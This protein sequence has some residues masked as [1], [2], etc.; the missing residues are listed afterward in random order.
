VAIAAALHLFLLFA[1]KPEFF[2]VFRHS[3]DDSPSAA[4]PSTSYP[5]AIA[6]IPIEI[7]ADHPVP[8]RIPEPRSNF[9]QPRATNPRK[10]PS[11]QSKDVLEIVS[12]SQVPRGGHA[13]TTRLR[14]PPRPIQ[15][16]WPRTNGLGHCLDLQIVIRI[17][18]A[19]DG[20]IL[21]TR[22]GSTTYPADCVRAAIDAAGRI[23]FAPGSIDG[24]PAAMWTRVR[25][26]FRHT[27]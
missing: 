5:N 11:G 14:V 22:A 10:G 18:V 26:D 17:H 9:P 24:K 15:I 1:L 20:S 7:D 19:S 8:E 6:V 4:S 2:D 25:I 23:H 16:T 3:I 27:R 21:E 12:K 13:T